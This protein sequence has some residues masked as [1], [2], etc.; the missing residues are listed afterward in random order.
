MKQENNYFYSLSKLKLLTPKEENILALGS[1]NGD[2]KSRN[3]LVEHNLKL[4]VHVAK[5]YNGRGLEFYDLI[6]EGNL[7]LI[8]AAEKF[9][10]SLGYRFSTYAIWWIREAIEKAL[11]N[12]SELIRVPVYMQKSVRKLAKNNITKKH[13]VTPN[14]DTR[15]TES[16]K[17]VEIKEL[18]DKIRC[19]VSIESQDYSYRESLLVSREDEVFEE[20]ARQNE[21]KVYSLKKLITRLSERHATVINHRFGLNDCEIMSLELLGRKLNLT[22]ERIRQLQNDAIKE[23]G[24]LIKA[25]DN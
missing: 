2:L 11:F 12:K 10:P 9:D 4:V 21:L 15:Q 22:R 1:S 24:K 20:V 8:R 19:P 5:K 14:E 6:N 23:L 17:L 16:S 13:S 25:G 18:I 3:K 7:G